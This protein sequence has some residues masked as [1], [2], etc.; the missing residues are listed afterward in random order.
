MKIKTAEEYLKENLTTEII[1]N[2]SPEY[3]YNKILEIIEGYHNQFKAKEKTDVVFYSKFDHLK[4]TFEDFDRLI[5]LG[6]SK[7]EI[8]DCIEKI[9]N[10]AKNKSYKSLFLTLKNWL[11]NSNVNGKQI[12]TTTSKQSTIDHLRGW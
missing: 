9:Q 10:Y 8:D 12:A 6:H 11:K 1:L 7:S 4:L 5:N 2:N 3:T